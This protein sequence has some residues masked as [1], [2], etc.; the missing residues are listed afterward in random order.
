MNGR[1]FYESV[2]DALGNFLPPALRDFSRYWTAHNLK[3]WY[4]D[5]RR[6]HYEVQIIPARL[7]K[8]LEIDGPALEIGFH[9]EYKERARN[10]DV[11]ERL[12]GEERKWR[13]A[14][15][16]EVE[17]GP[18]IGYQSGSW[19]RI[20]ELWEDA[21]GPEAAIEAAERLAAYVRALEPLR[22]S[23]AKAPGGRSA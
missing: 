11:L 13:R 8:S 9:A 21:D 15:G 19:R 1:A 20:S 7:L 18:F 10:E 23:G 6:E 22:A 4:G 16:K 17:A 12:L 14:L 5:E 3:L 2:A